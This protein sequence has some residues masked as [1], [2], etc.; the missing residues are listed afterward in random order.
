MGGMI[1]GGFLEAGGRGGFRGGL[2]F[3][4]ERGREGGGEEGKREM[5]EEWDLS[6]K[7]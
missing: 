2:R 4:G 5:R 1:R 3:R 7:I 6:Y